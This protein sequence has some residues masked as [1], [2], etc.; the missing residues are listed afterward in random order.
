MTRTD[1][2]LV[3]RIT[4]MVLKALKNKGLSGQQPADIHAPIGV[5]TGD[6]SKFTDRPD[7][8]VSGK[9]ADKESE[10]IL[11]RGFITGERVD[12]VKG[13]ILLLDAKAK[14][15]PLGADRVK[16]RRLTVKRIFNPQSE[17]RNSKTSTWYWWIDGVCP[18]VEK[19]TTN[20][21]NVLVPLGTSHDSSQLH[22]VVRDASRSV[23]SGRVEGV[24]LFVPSSAL[25]GC[26]ANRCPSLR[27]VVATC[28]EAVE[29]GIELLGANVLIVEYPH[30][31][32][33]S[34]LA[35]VDRFI[36]G[37]RPDLPRINQQLKELASCG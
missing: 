32:Y 35:M 22:Q 21:K 15:T 7:L 1:S 13:G 25:V 29:Q 4:Q 19:L 2:Q 16:E 5:C 37:K 28:D 26:Y 36:S 34:M 12:A 31:G 18:A 17:I 33:R 27:A 8:A 3:D 20:L 9:A 11:L 6:Y 14:L 24:I 10:A 30:H 23:R